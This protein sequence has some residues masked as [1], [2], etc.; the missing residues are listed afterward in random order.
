MRWLRAGFLPVS[1]L[2]LLLAA[3]FV[4][5]PVFL[6]R[7]GRPVSLAACVAVDH[8]R[9][10]PVQGDYLLMTISVAPGTSVDVLVAAFDAETGVVGQRRIIPPGVNPDTYFRQ[11]RR[12]FATT[13]DVAAAVGLQAAG[14][15]AEVT[16]DGISVLQTAPDT[17][18]SEVLQP[19][20]IITAV[21]RTA[22]TMEAELREAV[23]SVP[24]GE[25]LLLEITRGGE[26]IE[27]EI[28]A[29]E[30][31][32]SPVIGV[33]PETVNPR[34]TLPVAVDVA[35]GAT[36]GPSAGLTIALTV[37]DQVLPG[38][39]LAAGRV[40]AGTGTID[41][42]GRVGP[43]GGVGLKVI[44]AAR[45]GAEIFLAPAANY[46]EA[47]AALP[48]DSSMEIVKVDT[49]EQARQALEAGAAN[50]AQ[51]AEDTPECPYGEPG[52][53]SAGP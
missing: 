33:I 27:V 18:A 13:A 25:P 36:G 32:G 14:L 44:A 43:I 11:Q 17:P 24:V 48:A 12:A 41:H 42:S 30:A 49:F 52:S 34:V 9:A 50:G 6:E 51:K 46:D 2:V 15:S 16:G 4:P 21:N 53:A 26:D 1:L 40:I 39:D 10:T 20:D 47:V 31:D 19:G 5:L 29:V 45:A 35:S 38:V 23:G 7:P 22:V 8:E 28:T 37:Y 3:L